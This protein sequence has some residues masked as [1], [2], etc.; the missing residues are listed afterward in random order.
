VELVINNFTA[1]LRDWFLPVARD[2]RYESFSFLVNFDFSAD[3]Q[4]TK[5]INFKNK[6]PEFKRVLKGFCSFIAAQWNSRKIVLK[7]DQ[8]QTL[9]IQTFF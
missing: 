1:R 5:K 4:F 9:Q 3:A 6:K 7:S 2:L 8:I